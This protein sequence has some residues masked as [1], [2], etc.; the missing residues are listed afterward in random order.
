MSVARFTPTASRSRYGGDSG[1]D[2]SRFAASY[3]TDTK[4]AVIN[5]SNASARAL[6]ES[7]VGGGIK[8]NDIGDERKTSRLTCG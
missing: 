7:T 5:R 2:R 3:L 6:R 8:R 1:A 4:F